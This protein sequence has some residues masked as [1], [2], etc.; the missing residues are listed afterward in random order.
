MI[1]KKIAEKIALENGLTENE[2]PFE[3][4]FNLEEKT[5]TELQMIIYGKPYETIREGNTIKESFVLL[6]LEPFT[7]K[8][9]NVERKTYNGIID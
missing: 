1:S 2:M 5:K 3:Y 4:K 7:G 9:L 6:T 8:V